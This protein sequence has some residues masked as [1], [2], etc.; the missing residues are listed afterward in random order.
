MA[1]LYYQ[2]TCEDG[3][4]VHIARAFSANDTLIDITLTSLSPHHSNLVNF[5]CA[6]SNSLKIVSLL[7][8]VLRV[9]ELPSSFTQWE[10]L[11]KASFGGSINLLAALHTEVEHS[12]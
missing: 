10:P 2:A 4:L 12:E 6:S 1:I 7:P 3:K 11:T 9:I 8:S 5:V